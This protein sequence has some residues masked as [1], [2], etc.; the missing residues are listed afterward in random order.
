MIKFFQD[1]L[2]ECE[3]D[4]ILN[5]LNN[6]DPFEIFWRYNIYNLNTFQYIFLKKDNE[7]IYNIVKKSN[8]FKTIDP[9]EDSIINSIEHNTIFKKSGDFYLYF[10][11]KRIISGMENK[12][13]GILLKCLSILIKRGFLNSYILNFIYDMIEKNLDRDNFYKHTGLYYRYRYFGCKFLKC[14]IKITIQNAINERRKRVNFSSIDNL[15]KLVS[16]YVI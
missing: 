1:K 4:K 12:D 2:N 14:I 6:K 10:I 3:N 5:I 7:F 16:E 13:M 8:K 11:V 9:D 15:N